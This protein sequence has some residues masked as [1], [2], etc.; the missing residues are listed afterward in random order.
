MTQLRANLPN[1]KDVRTIDL[2]KADVSHHISTVASAAKNDVS[3]VPAATARHL[4]QQGRDLWNLCIRLKRSDA[5]PQEGRHLLARARMLAYC[6]I[7]ASRARRDDVD[8]A[9]HLLGL[10]LIASRG[11]KE[12]NDLDSLRALLERAAAFV[13]VLDGHSESND[14]NSLTVE[15]FAMRLALVSAPLSSNY[16]S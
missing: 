16:T 15:Y 8:N 6:V 10:V 7:E 5:Y 14:S 3:L 1:I 2:L 9:L 12:V 4:E 11:C 13:L